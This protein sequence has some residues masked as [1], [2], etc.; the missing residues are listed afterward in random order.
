MLYDTADYKANRLFAKHIQG[1]GKGLGLAIQIVLTETLPQPFPS[2]PDFVIS[3]QRNHR[4][5]A[6]F[7]AEGIPVFN[8]ARVCEICNDKRSTIAFWMDCR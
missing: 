3:R 5:S 4:L 7:E 2:L 1:I 6:R 8:C